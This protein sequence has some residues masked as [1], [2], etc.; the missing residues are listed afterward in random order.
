M[1]RRPLEPEPG[2]AGGGNHGTTRSALRVRGRRLVFAGGD[3]PV[4]DGLASPGADLVIAADSGLE[5]ALALGVRGRPR[6]RR[7]RLGRS[8]RRS[9]PRSPTA[10]SS[11][12][13][14]RPRTPPISS[15]RSTPPLDRGATEVHRGRRSAAAA[16]TTSSATCSCSRSPPLRRRRA[17]TPASATRTS[18]VVRE[19]RR[20]RRRTVGGLCSLLPVGGPRRRRASPTGCGSRCTARRSPPARRAASATSSSA[21]RATVSLDDGVLLAVIPT[22]GTDRPEMASDAS[23]RCSPCVVHRR[24]R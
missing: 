21:T 5:H 20:A 14:P 13:T 9:T 1:R 12:V 24:R 7:S 10:R 19:R 8:A 18:T 11:N 3:P 4:R 17:S 16:S 15:S 22:P 6:R 23:P 2:N